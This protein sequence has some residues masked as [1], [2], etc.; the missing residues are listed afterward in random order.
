MR[1]GGVLWDV[2]KARPDRDLIPPATSRCQGAIRVN[3]DAL[4][5]AAALPGDARAG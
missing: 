3:L 4:P 5:L 2:V 1:V